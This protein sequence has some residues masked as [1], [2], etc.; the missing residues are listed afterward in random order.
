M[1]R[2]VS[3][4]LDFTV[5]SDFA[6]LFVFGVFDGDEAGA[7]HGAENGIEIIARHAAGGIDGFLQGAGCLV[8]NGAKFIGH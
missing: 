1:A 2:P 7:G 4:R 3:V 6:V 5:A 8:L